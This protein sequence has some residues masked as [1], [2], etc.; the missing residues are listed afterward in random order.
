MPRHYGLADLPFRVRPDWIAAMH[1]ELGLTVV[2]GG[3][4][5]QSR[6]DHFVFVRRGIPSLFVHQND[7]QGK[8]GADATSNAHI[9]DFVF[10]VAR[11]LANAD[12]P[13]QWNAVGRRRWLRAVGQ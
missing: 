11:D 1:P 7:S 3:T 5:A 4:V 13:L 2:D 12:Q 8:A 6:S 9:L 10:H